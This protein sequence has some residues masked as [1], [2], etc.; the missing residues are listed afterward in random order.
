MA[1][2][3]LNIG[4]VRGIKHFIYCKAP[5]I[6]LN[7]YATLVFL[8]SKVVSIEGVAIAMFIDD[9]ER[10]D[11]LL[12]EVRPEHTATEALIVVI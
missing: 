12:I 10:L 8:S 5:L 3:T 7:A 9:S 2:F 6:R 11:R 4:P 1:V